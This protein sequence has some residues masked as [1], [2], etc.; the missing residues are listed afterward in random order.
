MISKLTPVQESQID[1]YLQ[2]WL[3]IGYRTAPIEQDKAFNAVSFFYK[4]ILKKNIPANIHF[5]SSPLEG[6]LLCNKLAGNSQSDLK[7][8]EIAYSNWWISYYGMYDYILH[9]LFP[10]ES[11]TFKL[12]TMFLEHV[13]NIH[14][15]WMFDNTAILCDFPSAINVDKD[16]NLHSHFTGALVYRD[17][18]QVYS[19]NGSVL[20]KDEWAVK[21]VMY[22]S[23][24]GKEIFKAL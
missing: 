15:I 5:V 18:Y 4:D 17:G 11:H 21:T 22:Q 6:Q 3:E 7:Y 13:K 19:I 2:K 9:V 12:F 24:L 8:F 1:V 10:Q 23:S 14:I 20:S 16:S